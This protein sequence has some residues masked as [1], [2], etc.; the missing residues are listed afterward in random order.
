M[1]KYNLENWTWK[2][3]HSDKT[4]T[5]PNYADIDRKTLQK[6]ILLSEDGNEMFSMD[7]KKNG[8]LFVR[9]SSEITK[10]GNDVNVRSR[11]WKVGISNPLNYFIIQDDGTVSEHVQFTPKTQTN[12]R[13]D[14]I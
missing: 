6:F 2:A 11:F 12:F 13:D 4:V 1:M 14:E 5:S 9:L 10:R 8:K 7:I 3:V